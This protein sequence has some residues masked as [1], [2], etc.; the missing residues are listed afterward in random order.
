[1]SSQIQVFNLI[2]QS[3]EKRIKLNMYFT[4][5]INLDFI[6]HDCRR[7]ES[8]EL[9]RVICPHC[10]SEFTAEIPMIIMSESL[11]FACVVFPELEQRGIDA[12][13]PP[14]TFLLPGFEF[15][16]VRYQAEA[17]EKLRI[18]NAGC[19]DVDIEYIKCVSFDSE[20]ALPFDEKNLVFQ[21]KDNNVYHFKQIDFNN[22][23]I[24]EYQVTFDDENIPNFITS[25]K[26]N[27]CNKKWHKIDRITIKEEINN[28]KV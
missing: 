11:K 26:N 9:N 20:T 25:F 27:L 19:S 12:V 16:I 1:M 21:Y 14:P 24:A 5:M 22:S 6:S 28:A 4:T 7:F 10:N 13:T 23:V 2:C 8:G 3:C 18:K 17:L 15:R